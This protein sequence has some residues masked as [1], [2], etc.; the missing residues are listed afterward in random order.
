[1]WKPS[2]MSLVKLPEDA[3]CIATD[4]SWDRGYAT[5]T[6]NPAEIAGDSAVVN[7]CLDPWHGLRETVGTVDRNLRAELIHRGRVADQDHWRLRIDVGPDGIY[8]TA[9]VKTWPAIPGFTVE[10]QS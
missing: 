6:R 5:W 8:V 1:M 7:P 4:P 3:Q 10:D 9:K 2:P